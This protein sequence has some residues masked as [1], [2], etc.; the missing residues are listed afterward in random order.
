[1]TDNSKPVTEMTDAELDRWAAE[2][3][4]KEPPLYYVQDCGLLSGTW[5]CKC[6]DDGEI[7]IRQ[8]ATGSLDSAA[9]VE[10]EVIERVGHDKYTE[11]LEKVLW[12]N[13]IPVANDPFQRI[14]VYMF[15]TATARQRVMACVEAIREHE[16][17][18]K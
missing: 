17:S 9:L 14:D 1:M 5:H 16:R 13:L 4:E 8:H 3:M 12:P 15:I 18:G 10:A 7:I 2:F 6:A 11:A